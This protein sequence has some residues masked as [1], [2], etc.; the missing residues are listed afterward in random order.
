M[1]LC[2]SKPS[3]E[4]DD[5]P[6]YDDT[7]I[8]NSAKGLAIGHQQNPVKRE[9]PPP[10]PRPVTVTAKLGDQLFEWKAPEVKQFGN[11]PH[12]WFY[13]EH[14]VLVLVSGDFI[15]HSDIGTRGIVHAPI[16]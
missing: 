16:R 4:Y 10:E 2:V 9:F 3:R 8:A 15:V 5:R 14:G 7:Q 11:T 1:R 6:K 12:I 13:D